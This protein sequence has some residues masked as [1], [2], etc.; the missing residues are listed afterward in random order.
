MKLFLIGGRPCSGKTTLA[1]QLGK[2]YNI[3]VNHLDLFAQECINNST[4][5]HTYLYG[6]KSSSLI[7][8]LQNEPVELFSDYLKTYEQM[9]PFLLKA[10]DMSKEKLLLLE[11]T[12]LLPKFIPKLRKNYDVKICFLIT[13]D[14]FVRERY[15]SRP[16]VQEMLNNPNGEKAVLNLFNRDSI[17]SEYLNDEIAKHAFHKIVIHADDTIE[18]TLKRLEVV[19]GIE[20]LSV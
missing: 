4:E 17:F 20:A 19:L 14:A 16:Y 15:Y 12:I 18:A 5:Q 10:I 3:G 7:D 8:L 11:G 13:D 6:W 9:L 1:E 2:K